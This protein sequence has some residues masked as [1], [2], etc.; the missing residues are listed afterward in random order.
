MHIRVWSSIRL[1]ACALVFI[2]SLSSTR[3][4]SFYPQRPPDS[5]AATVT[6]PSGGDDT[7]LLQQAIDKVRDTTGQG[8]VFLGPGRYRLTNTVYIWPSIRVIGY[9]ATRPVI[10]LPSNTP[11]FQNS[12]T[13]R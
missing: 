3:A 13:E 1:S 12:N 9:G 2:A 5:R 10:V 8:I 6:V 7:A 11:G 4:A